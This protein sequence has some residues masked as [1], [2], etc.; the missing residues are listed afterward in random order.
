MRPSVLVGLTAC[1][2]FLGALG[3]GCASSDD[4]GGDSTGET[5]AGV[6]GAAKDWSGECSDAKAKCDDA[7][8]ETCDSVSSLLNASVL[9]AAGSCL[10]EKACGGSPTRCLAQSITKA[11]TRDSHKKLAEGFC[12][13]LLTGKEECI[14]SITS[15]DG[16]ASAALKIALPLGDS[17]AD[18]ITESCT[19]TMGC[20]ATFQACAQGVVAKKLAESVSTEAASCLVKSVLE[21]ST[22]ALSPGPGGEQ[23]AEPTET[24]PVEEDK[25]T[26]T[27]CTPKT[28]ADLG[29][30]CGKHPTGCGSDVDCGTC[31]SACQPKTCAQLGKSCGKHADGCG[32]TRDCGVCASTC[33]GG[34]AGAT[35]ETAF[36]LGA[37]TDSPDTKKSAYEQS[38]PDAEE[39]WF[40]SKVTDGGWDGN[41]RI[42]ASVAR[43]VEVTVFYKCDAGG[44]AST[45][46]N[47]VDSP[48]N[49]IGNGCKGTSSAQVKVSCSGISDN[50]TA[51]VRVRKLASDGQ[52]VSY[53]LDLFVD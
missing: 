32:G 38:L 42:T 10:K 1:A 27:Q 20:S 47:T 13:C 5:K 24:A 3:V 41:P 9:D 14:A 44:D 50:G 35:S 33:A 36:D 52:C 19:G 51:Y 46:P 26:G 11:K 45:C 4:G 30:T 31:A 37:T 15:K 2:L 39:D 21:A 48:D 43:A 22:A 34:S 17:L 16:P 53:S 18:A 49:T 7:I 23:P 29:E 40:K 6:C 25:S 12:G 8:V 28:C